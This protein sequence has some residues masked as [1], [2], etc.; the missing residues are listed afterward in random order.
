M[1]DKNSPDSFKSGVTIKAL[2][3]G[4]LL[5]FCIA[6][7]E[8]YGVAVLHGSAMCADFSTGGAIFLFFV[9]VLGV[10]VLLKCIGKKIRLSPSE[11][12]IVP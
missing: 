5:C 8:V 10:N 6:A 12:I 11:L 1:E 3:I 9:L 4:V 2:L 7:G